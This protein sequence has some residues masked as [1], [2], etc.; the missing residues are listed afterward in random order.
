[1][2]FHGHDIHSGQQ[3]AHVERQWFR[4]VIRGVGGDGGKLGGPGRHIDP[5]HLSAIQIDDGPV[6]LDQPSRE[7]DVEGRVID[8]EGLPEIGGDEL[9]AGIGPEADHGGLIPVAITQ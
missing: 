9:V 7:T 4:R 1:M 2:Y 3:L 8:G 5:E 6:I